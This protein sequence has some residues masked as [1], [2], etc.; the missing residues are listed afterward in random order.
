MRKD[1]LGAG[2]TKRRERG[3]RTLLLARRRGTQCGE[4][5]LGDLPDARGTWGRAR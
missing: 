1:Q 5:L 3:V 4:N 2:H